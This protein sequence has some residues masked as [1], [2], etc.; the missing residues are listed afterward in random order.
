MNIQTLVVTTDQKD[1]SLLKKM[2]I[3][4]PAIVGN[5]CDR[6]EIEE[7][8]YGGN[9][10]KWLSLHERGVGLNRNTVLMRS[11]ADVCVLADDDMVFI[12]GYEKVVSD[13]FDR[14]PHTDVLIF[15]L[16]QKSPTIYKNSNVKKIH[17]F[18]YGKYGAARLAFRR[19]SVQFNNICFHLLFGGGAKYSSGEDSI[20]LYECLKR[21]LRVLAVPVAIAELTSD[22]ESTWFQGYTDDFFFDKGVFYY[23]LDRNMG[24]FIALYNCFK[25]RNSRYKQYGWK[26]AY[27]QM[28][29]GIHS[30]KK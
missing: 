24:R 14:Y 20:F 8:S 28:L 15:N 7:F 6:D 17:R 23:A 11:E 2:N 19:E 29:R 16:N 26:K 3:Q 1:Y 22:R 10:V 5:Q 4:T 25:H 21:K 18:N 27:R 12:D 30:V 9:P 13:L